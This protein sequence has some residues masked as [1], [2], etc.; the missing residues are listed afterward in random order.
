MKLTI[1]HDSPDKQG[2]HILSYLEEKS[3]GNEQ[4]HFIDLQKADMEPCIGCFNCWLKTP[5]LCIFKDDAVDILKEEINSDRVMY[6]GPVTWGSYSPALK[7]LQDRSLGR[8]LP[9]FV[10][11]KGETHHPHRYEKS[12]IPYIAGYGESI[13]SDEEDIFRIT[14]ANLNDNIHKGDMN[15]LIIRSEED[16]S[17]FD[18]F[19][20]DPS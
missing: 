19:F 6:L 1:I 12:A 4:V 9:F 10:T 20:G 2:Q 14:G 5:G 17:L 7:I 11:H 3:R 18:N 16:Y 15:T 8:V 13:D